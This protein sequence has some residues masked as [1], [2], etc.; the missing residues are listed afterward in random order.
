MREQWG[1]RC[2]ILH[3]ALHQE[4]SCKGNV[5]RS[6]NSRHVSHTRGGIRP[7]VGSLNVQGRYSIE[8]VMNKRMDESAGKQHEYVRIADIS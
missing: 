8:M 1:F 3:A 2:K 7:I 5:I 6:C 4:E